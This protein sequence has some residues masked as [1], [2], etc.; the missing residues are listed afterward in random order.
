[1]SRC[2]VCGGLTAGGGRTLTGRLAC[3]AGAARNCGRTEG[4]LERHH[5]AR[6]EAQGLGP[7]PARRQQACEGGRHFSPCGPILITQEDAANAKLGREKESK[8]FSDYLPYFIP[9]RIRKSST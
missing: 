1:M 4:P 7:A 2:L 9:H 6:T 3:T 8:G 5:G